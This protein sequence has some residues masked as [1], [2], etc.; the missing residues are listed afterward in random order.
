VRQSGWRLFIKRAFDRTAGALGLV[1]AAPIM[2]GVAVLIRTTL[3]SPVLFAQ[4]RPGYRGEIFT[5]YKFR[6][7]RAG[8]GSD[9]ER[10]TTVGRVVRSFSLDELPQLFN[11]VRGEMSLV[12]PRPLLPEYLAR[13]TAEQARRHD[14]LPGITGW[15]VLNLRNAAPW[16]EK[17]AQDVW[18]VDHWSL[19]LDARILMMT[20][21]RVLQRRGVSQGQ[22]ATMPMF[23]GES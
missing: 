1:A 5:I 9:A 21:V 19:L 13:Y 2:A 8:A 7:M 12:G 20:I 6:T 11:V 18:Y 4:R 10:L 15:S 17:L 16:P 3:G 22:H 14:V 23:A